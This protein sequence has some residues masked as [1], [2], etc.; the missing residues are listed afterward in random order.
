M[1]QSIIDSWQAKLMQ[2][3]VNLERSQNQ[4]AMVQRELVHRSA[5]LV[6][7]NSLITAVGS[8]KEQFGAYDHKMS[9]LI[10]LGGLGISDDEARSY[11]F[12]Q[13]YVSADTKVLATE[14]GRFTKKTHYERV[15]TDT[16]N[17]FGVMLVAAEKDGA[18]PIM[19]E[20]IDWSVVN[21]AESNLAILVQMEDRLTILSSAVI[22]LAIAN[23]Q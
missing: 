13:V 19:F 20:S 17:R 22:D 4:A 10:P 18:N 21:T 8:T 5:T 15:T 9:E 11:G 7:V 3:Q 6:V 14:T 1:E 12:G 23:Y 2:D 16:V